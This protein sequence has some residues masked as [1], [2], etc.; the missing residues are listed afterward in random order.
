[1]NVSSAAA[2]S[3]M[4]TNGAMEP[5][6][7]PAST[8]AAVFAFLASFLLIFSFASSLIYFERHGTP[9]VIMTHTAHAHIQTGLEFVDAICV[10]PPER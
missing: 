10:H 7:K 1:M 5:L 9:G 8:F 3:T 6:P 4:N 2:V